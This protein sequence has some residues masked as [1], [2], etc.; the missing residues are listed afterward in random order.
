MAEESDGFRWC[1][2]IVEPTLIRT[3]AK[4]RKAIQGWRYLEGPDAPRDRGF[5]A[6][7][8][9]LPPEDMEEELKKL[10]LL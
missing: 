9:E 10:G 4:P 1:Q 3:I 6:Q 7:N 2:I 8:E 5:Q